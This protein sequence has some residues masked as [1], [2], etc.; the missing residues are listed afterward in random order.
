MDTRHRLFFALAAL[1]AVSSS[2][3]AQSSGRDPGWEYGLDL[4]YL[5]SADLSFKGGSTTGRRR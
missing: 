2:A 4:V 3:W 1:T 5:D